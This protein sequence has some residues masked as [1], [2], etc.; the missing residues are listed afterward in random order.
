MH[1]TPN[2]LQNGSPQGMP[3]RRVFVIGATGTIGQATVRALL[4][5]GHQVVCF[6]RPRA[7]VREPWPRTQAGSCC[8]APQCALGR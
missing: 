6:V 1:I 5:R 4:Q 8:K 2:A 3:P 7:G